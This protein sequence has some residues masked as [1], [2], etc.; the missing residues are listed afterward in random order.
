MIELFFDGACEPFNPNGTASCGFVIKKE[1]KIIAKGSKIIGEGEGMTNNV[2]EYHGLIEGI[3]AFCKLGI[4]EKLLIYG[5]SNMVCSIVSKKW[6]WNK[7]KTKWIPHKDVPHLKELLEEVMK[8]LEQ[9]DYEINWIPREKNQEADDLSKEPLLIAG[10]IKNNTEPQK[11]ACPRCGGFLKKRN[12]KFGDFYGCSNYPRC[13]FTKKIDKGEEM[14]DI[15]SKIKKKHQEGDA[16]PKNCGGN[17]YWVSS[18]LTEKRLKK[19]YHFEKS[20]RCKKCGAIFLDDDYKVMH[21][22]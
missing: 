18:K 6:G 22:I 11:E 10:I 13:D 15:K 7:K 20:L 17:L 5:D 12:G 1:G 16:C 9:I 4:N 14:I 21:K 2:G 19:A 8:I 3:K